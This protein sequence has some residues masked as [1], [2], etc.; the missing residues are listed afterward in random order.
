M[1]QKVAT[2]GSKHQRAS[3]KGN[4]SHSGIAQHKEHC[5]ETVNWEPEVIKMMSNKNKNKISVQSQSLRP[6]R[7]RVTT[8]VLTID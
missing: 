4:W 5:K 3:E 8:V 2:C 6:S 1:T 7:Y